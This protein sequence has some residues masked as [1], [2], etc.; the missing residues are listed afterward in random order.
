M[1]AC[2]I[3]DELTCAT[4][5]GD[6]G[7]FGVSATARGQTGSACDGMAFNVAVSDPATGAVRFTPQTPG[8]R[9]HAAGGDRPA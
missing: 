1:P 4:G 8:E 6:P 7:V 5:N 9:G 3:Q 2:A